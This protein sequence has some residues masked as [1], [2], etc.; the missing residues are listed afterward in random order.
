VIRP[1]P[2]FYTESEMAA[3]VRSPD[4]STLKGRRDRAILATL[5]ACGLRASELCQLKARDVSSSLV[6]V[7][8]GKGGR[9]RYVPLSAKA[10][11]TVSAYLDVQPARPDEPVFRT[12]D[13]RPITRRLLHKLVTGYSLRL[14][15]Q[16][17]VHVLRS[18]AA[19][20]WLNRGVNLQSVRLMLGHAQIATTALYLKLATEGLVAEYRRCVE[21]RPALAQLAIGGDAR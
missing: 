20:F 11:A 19:T 9:Q 17:G 13:G 2:C 10:W 7:R 14:G 16:G 18:S 1:L 6:F 4:T 15:L 3:L 21:R 12:L 5:C 8:C